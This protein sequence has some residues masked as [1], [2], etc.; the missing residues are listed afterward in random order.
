MLFHDLET[1]EELKRI[2][3][4]GLVDHATFSHDGRRAAFSSGRA[5]RVW[6]LPTGRQPGEQPSVVEIARF[7]GHTNGLSSVAIS[8]DGFSLLTGSRDGTARLW[9]VRSGRELHAFAEHRDHVNCVAFLP[10][11]RSALS[12]GDDDTVRLWDL[13]TGVQRLCLRGPGNVQSVAVSPDGLLGLSGDEQGKVRLWDLKVGGAEL[14][15]FSG[16]TAIVEPGDFPA[17]WPAG[18]IV[19]RRRDCLAVGPEN[20]S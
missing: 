1:G 5:V 4:Q 2:E 16:H 14:W 3:H 19:E 12:G 18:G 10:D 13:E 11:G 7:F 17:G 6:A 15:T 20:G 9:D 8:P